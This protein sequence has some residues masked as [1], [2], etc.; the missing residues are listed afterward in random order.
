MR[1]VGVVRRV[2]TGSMLASAVAAC[3]HGSG[4]AAGEA[5]SFEQLSISQVGQILR[6]YQQGQKPPP[7]R[8]R[9]LLLLENGY[10]AAIAPIRD[11]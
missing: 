7:K 2:I 11:R 10:P 9:D 5:E 8:L 4:R 3:G 6:D 1:V